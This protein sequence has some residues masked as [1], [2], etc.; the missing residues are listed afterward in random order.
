MRRT[1]AAARAAVVTAHALAAATRLGVRLGARALAGRGETP[2]GI[3]GRSMAELFQALGPCYVKLG[4]LLSTRRDLLAEDS[5]RHLARLQ[6]GLPPGPFSRVSA[7]FRRELHREVGDVFAELDPAAVA[8]ASIATV[9]RGRLRDGRVVAVKVRRPEVARLIRIDLRLLKGA[10]S[11]LARIPPLRLI[12]VVAA[13]DDFCHCLE[14]QLDFGREAA[15]SRRLRDA[16]RCEPGVVVPELVDELCSPSILTMEFIEHFR[17]PDGQGG[18]AARRALRSG[19]RALYRMIFVEGCIHCDLHHGN[20]GLLADGRAALLDFGFV[21]E[22]GDRARLQF[23]EFFYAMATNDGA[24]CARI[25]RDTALSVPPGLDYEAF[26]TEVVALVDS[27][28]RVP[29]SEFRV[30]GFVGRLFDLQRRYR[31]RGTSDFVMPILSL[32]VLEGIV[33]DVY[34]DLD[35]QR[36]G[37][38]Y[39]LRASI[40]GSVPSPAVRTP[41]EFSEPGWTPRELAE[42][43]VG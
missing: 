29:A 43:L 2:A 32:L 35:F 5:I 11:V 40:R 14:R 6:D 20:L 21:A 37:Q 25:T 4:Q 18:E 26:Q 23:A 30:A 1:T 3:L 42:A 41:P 38:P 8:S 16:L 12:P 31:L 34:P 17:P 9:Y 36:E 33:K 13:V 15:A 24:R 22:I 28:S 27:V 19:V 39:V 10:A 7:L